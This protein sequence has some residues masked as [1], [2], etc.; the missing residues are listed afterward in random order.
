MP[1]QYTVSPETP[2][3]VSVTVETGSGTTDIAVT[4]GGRGAAG[5]PGRKTVSA[6]APTNP[7][8]GDEWFNTESGLTYTYYDSTW[9]TDNP[10][11][12]TGSGTVDNAS[13]NTAIEED[14]AATRASLGLGTAATTA[15]TAYA[16]AAQG[17]TADTALQS[18]RAGS[19]INGTATINGTSDGKYFSTGSATTVTLATATGLEGTRCF[20]IA[21]AGTITLAGVSLYGRV[22]F[23]PISSIV[24]ADGLCEIECINNGSA[25]VWVCTKGVSTPASHTHGGISNAGAIGSTAN[26]PVF[27]GT[28]GVL[29]AVSTLS[30][31]RGY[32]GAGTTGDSLFTASTAASAMTTLGYVTKERT[33]SATAVINSTTRVADSTL[34]GWSL[35]ANTTY[36]CTG[37]LWCYADTGGMRVGLEFS[38]ALDSRY[39][40]AAPGF[41]FLSHPEA[42]GLTAIS[43][44]STLNELVVLDRTAAIDSECASFFLRFRTG[45][46]A[47]TAQFKYAQRTATNNN[48]AY[49]LANSMVTIRKVST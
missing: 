6:T 11:S 40:D 30:T 15:A 25:A 4:T 2:G 45:T 21:E 10:S 47:P 18:I 1:A 26:L 39:A 35:E 48:G 12:T 9:V 3:T 46:V 41:G 23:T 8:E 20:V 38:Q 24:S 17:T 27:T 14:A 22:D 49:L 13:V 37:S 33:S 19:V 7:V 32:L 29:G 16:T 34:T 43:K 31:A 44:F 28:A 5:V 42:I 36:E